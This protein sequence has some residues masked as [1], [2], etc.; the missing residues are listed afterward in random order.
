ME[1]IFCRCEGAEVIFNGSA[2]FFSRFRTFFSAGSAPM[3]GAKVLI[4]DNCPGF[5]LPN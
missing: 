4:S 3:R 5:H 2:P 1:I